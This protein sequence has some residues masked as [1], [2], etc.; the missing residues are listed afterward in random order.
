MSFTLDVKNEIKVL[1]QDKDEK[2]DFLRRVFLLN[3]SVMDPMTEYHLEI[4]S[5]SKELAETICE[6]LI[7]FGINAKIIEKKYNYATYVKE[8]ESIA[9]FLNIIGAHNALFNFENVKVMHEMNN[10]I[11]R[12][13]NC[14][15]AN[16]SKIVNAAV[17]QIEAINT[18]KDTIGLSNLPE[19]LREIAELRLK[20]P[21]MGLEELGK[22]LSKPLGKSGVNHRFKRIEE[23]ANNQIKCIKSKG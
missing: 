14:E 19:G 9:L 1:E 23:I 13:V 21:D 11:N 22:L 8:A 5:D 18:I 10:Q 4:V 17:R 16:L 6:I 2:K 3:G 20:N 12:V 15:T 7:E